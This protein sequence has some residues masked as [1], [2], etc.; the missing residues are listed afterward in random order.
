MA[1]TVA[2]QFGTL[3]A[4]PQDGAPGLT[5]FEKD[6]LDDVFVPNENPG[7]PDDPKVFPEEL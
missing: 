2:M 6:G 3:E 5:G 4:D 7:L 1:M